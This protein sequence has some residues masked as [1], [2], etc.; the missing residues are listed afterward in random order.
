[1]FKVYAKQA[2]PDVLTHKSAAQYI[3]RQHNQNVAPC[4]VLAT[5]SDSVDGLPCVLVAF[6]YRGY[7]ATA[8]V[9]VESNGKL[10][11]EW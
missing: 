8:T 11:G 10:Y 3:Q 7:K 1:M 6:A 4:N 2:K 5:R 9:W